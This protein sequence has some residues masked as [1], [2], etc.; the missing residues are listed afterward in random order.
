LRRKKIKISNDTGLKVNTKNG[1][2][3]TLEEL[4]VEE[5]F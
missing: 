1:D 2:K 4:K 3:K 5:F